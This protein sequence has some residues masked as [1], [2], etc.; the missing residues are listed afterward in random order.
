MILAPSETDARSGAGKP[1]R[2]AG[3]TCL[4]LD[5]ELVTCH[6]KQQRDSST[7]PPKQCNRWT[8]SRGVIPKAPLFGASIAFL[9]KKGAD[10]ILLY[11][12]MHLST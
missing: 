8:S 10:S 2:K 4:P 7:S 3:G 6:M 1:H 5:P 12:A 9:S 11:K